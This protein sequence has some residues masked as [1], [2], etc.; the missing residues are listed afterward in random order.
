MPSNRAQRRTT[1][2]NGLPA[3]GQLQQDTDQAFT[4]AIDS[5]VQAEQHGYEDDGGQAGA[6]A[7]WANGPIRAQKNHDRMKEGTGSARDTHA[8]LYE[9]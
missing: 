8:D 4:S 7:P 2:A 5:H 6:L 9:T 3:T 1:V